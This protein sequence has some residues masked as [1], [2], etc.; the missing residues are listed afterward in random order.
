MASGLRAGT[1]N[2]GLAC[3]A[4]VLEK[5][6]VDIKIIDAAAEN[7]SYDG[8]IERIREFS[9]HL[10]GAG[11]QTPVS[12]RSLEIFR[13][14][15]REVGSDIVTIAGGPHFTFTDRESLEACPELDIVVRGEG[16]ATISHLCRQ[17]E[18][19]ES[20]EAVQR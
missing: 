13:R 4:A 9:P 11:G 10:I 6:G 14:T 18:A 15:K 5:D 17:I 19:G 2:L 3:I 16:E 12:P 1:P 20:L 7:L 8:I